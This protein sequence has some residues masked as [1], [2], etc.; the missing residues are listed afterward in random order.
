MS[1]SLPN[2]FT[3]EDLKRYVSALNFIAAEAK[4]GKGEPDIK[5]MIEARNHFAFLQSISSKIEGNVAEI[6]SMKLKEQD[7]PKS[8]KTK[9][10]K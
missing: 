7:E 2:K 1:G 3:E 6:K 8:K 9:K 4:F 5:Y 10:A